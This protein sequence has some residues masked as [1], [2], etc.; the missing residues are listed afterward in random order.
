[1]ATIRNLITGSLRLLNVVQAN[2]TPTADDMDISLKSM[3]GML[4]SWSTEKLTMFLLK[5]YYFPL[6]AG[7]KEYTVGAGGDWDISRPMQIEK[8]TVTLNGSLTLDGGVYT[9]IDNPNNY[10]IPTEGLTDAQ[11]ASIPVKNQTAPYPLRWY[12]NG[13]YPLRTLS[14]WPV[15]STSV[16]VTVW[17]WLPLVDPTTL[18]EELNFPKGYERAI[19][20]NLAYE[21]SAEFGKTVPD[22]VIRIAID[23]KAMLKRLNSRNQIMRGD[24]AIAGGPG[25]YNYNLSTT[26]PN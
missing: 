18:D 2:E 24:I 14:V 4:D 20:F 15:P 11:Y 16:P 13:N 26:I 25:I 3:Q 17:A 12:D 6:V 19:R 23:S 5:Q 9:L 22:D 21:L 10:D 8:I 7:Q 1:M